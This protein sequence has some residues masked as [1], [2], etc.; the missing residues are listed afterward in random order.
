VLIAGGYDVNY[1]TLASAEIFNPTSGAFTTTGS[2]IEG[3]GSPTATLLNDG[4]VLFVGGTDQGTNVPDAELY[5]PVA[6]SFSATGSPIDAR[7]IQTATLLPN[8]SVLQAGGCDANLNTFATAELY[9][10]ASLTPPNLVSIAISPSNSSIIVGTTQ[11]FT[12]TGTFSD[13]STEELLSVTWNSSD[14]TIASVSNDSGNDSFASGVSSGTATITACAGFTCGST[15]LTVGTSGAQGPTI[16]ALSPSVGQAGT[17]VTISGANFG[18]TQGTSTVSFNGTPATPAAWSP[19]STSILVPVPSGATSGNV[20]V[21]VGES[22]SNGVPFTVGEPTLEITSPADGAVVN[23]G[24]QLTVTVESPNNTPFSTAGVVGEDPIGLSDTSTSV[25]AQ[26][27]VSIPAAMTAGPH[28]LTAVGVTSAGQSVQSPTI[29]LDIERSDSPTSISSPLPLLVMGAQG[30]QAQARIIAT[31]SDGSVL[32]VTQSSNVTYS[33]PK[34]SIATV[35][36]TG[37]VT[38]VSPGSTWISA[39]YNSG[40]QVIAT[41]F[42]Q[43]LVLPFELTASPAAI[44]FGNQLVGTPATQSVTL[45]NTTQSPMAITSITTGGDFSESDDCTSGPIAAGAECNVNTI[46]T[47]SVSVAESGSLVVSTSVQTVP[48]IIPLSGTGTQGQ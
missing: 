19:T 16:T 17:I 29:S 32:D 26:L 30:E 11:Q 33:S 18:T 43:A 36:S 40:G 28:M 14:T 38:A 12:A 2:L 35:S 42:I 22:Q 47:P 44:N 24:D 3:R 5:D 21:T 31:F 34:T 45:K 6:A 25:P 27:S 46:F 8:G 20:V 23:E 9:Q 4:Q 37:T 39:S 13:N 1:N 41:A 48:T 7:Y 10:P 15:T